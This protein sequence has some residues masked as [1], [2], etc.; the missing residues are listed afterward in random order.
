MY[1][2]NVALVPQRISSFIRQGYISY[3]LQGAQSVFSVC[4]SE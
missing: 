4:I 2:N 3:Y 1:D